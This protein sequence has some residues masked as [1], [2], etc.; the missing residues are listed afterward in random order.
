MKRI[1]AIV[2]VGVIGITSFIINE[3]SGITVKTKVTGI[4]KHFDENG[5]YHLMI[6]T[7]H[8]N[9]LIG[10]RAWVNIGD[11]IVVAERTKTTYISC[12]IGIISA[13]IFSGLLSFHMQKYINS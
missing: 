10:V 9:R 12:Y 4:E 6:K 11:D 7:E 8:S 13:I 3:N 1:I 2:I 5:Q